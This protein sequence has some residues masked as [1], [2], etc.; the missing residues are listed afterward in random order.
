MKSKNILF[1]STSNELSIMAEGWASKLN[2]PALNFISTSFDKALDPSLSIEA[3]KEVNI[4]IT[5]KEPAPLAPKLINEAD[6]IVN[7]YD[8]DYDQG[9]TLPLASDKKVLYWDIPNPAY[10]KDVIEKWAAYQIVCDE[11]AEHVK[12]LEKELKSPPPKQ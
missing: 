7:I 3:M 8:S 9:P 5:D 1:F 6:L 2:E 4:D 11:L 10:C 12:Q